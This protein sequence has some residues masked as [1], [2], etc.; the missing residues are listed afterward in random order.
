MENIKVKLYSRGAQALEKAELLALLVGDEALAAALLA[1]CEGS[2]AKLTTTELS[3]LRM[4]EGLGLRRAVW[5]AACAELGRRV[6]AEKALKA[7]KITTSADIAELFRPQL[8]G[9]RHEECWAIYLSSSNEIEGR[10]QVSSG[11][12]QATVVDH[13][14]IVKQALQLLTPRLALVHNHPSGAAEASPQD[15]VLTERIAAA[16]A[17]FDI[18]LLDHVIIARSGHFS[19]RDTGLLGD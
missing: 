3:R 4:L 17:L 14:L 6:A 5:L 18:Y 12:V 8:Q 19:F 15:R 11:G 2:L 1:A 10:L 16:A 13:R 9:L 7:R